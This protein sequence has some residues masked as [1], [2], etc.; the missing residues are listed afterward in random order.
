M[1][2]D[3]STWDLN[4]ARTHARCDHTQRPLV[5]I[6]CQDAGLNR[7]AVRDRFADV[8]SSVSL[9][10]GLHTQV[11]CH[12]IRL[13]REYAEEIVLSNTARRELEVIMRETTPYE[14]IAHL[15]PS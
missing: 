15:S 1:Q 9:C 5:S 4:S 12:R 8:S 2:Q 11:P 7:L 3:A 13:P 10:G 14:H 6:S